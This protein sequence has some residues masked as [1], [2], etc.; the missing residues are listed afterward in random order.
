MT[1]LPGTV[2]GERVRFEPDGSLFWPDGRTLFVADLHLGKTAAFR[3]AG[4]AVPEGPTDDTLSRL[5]AA[6]ERTAASRLI[7]LGDMWHEAVR[8][9]DPTSDRLRR[10]RASWPAVEV[11]LV[12]GNHDRRFR[13]LCREIGVEVWEPGTEIDPFRVAHHPVEAEDGV[14]S[15]GGHLHPVVRIGGRA[16]VRV[17]C[18]WG[19]GH[20]WVLP[21]FGSFT[22]GFSVEPAPGDRVVAAT[23]RQAIAVRGSW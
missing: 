2:G 12:P 15:L 8:P 23:G 22:G 4:V 14:P 6:L 10:W 9:D 13:D 16:S 7:V 17:R 3:R 19:R 18:F 20:T 1:G 21:A 5:G 11:G